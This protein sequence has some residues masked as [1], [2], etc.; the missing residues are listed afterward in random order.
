[1]MT[2]Y[3][4]CS[5]LVIRATIKSRFRIESMDVWYYNDDGGPR[6]SNSNH[7]RDC[8]IHPGDAFV[9]FLNLHK[10]VWAANT[11]H[12]II[13]HRRPYVPAVF[14]LNMYRISSNKGLLRIEA[15]IN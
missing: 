10:C 2:H 8:L 1:M 4:C 9:A 7:I 5:P 12:L 6:N 11:N 15:G 3:K 14:P 13:K